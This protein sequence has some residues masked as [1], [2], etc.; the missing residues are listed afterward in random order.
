M[1]ANSFAR[2]GGGGII[3]A[4]LAGAASGSAA[5][6]TASASHGGRM[7]GDCARGDAGASRNEIRQLCLNTV[8]G[9]QTAGG[10]QRSRGG[11][12]FSAAFSPAAFSIRARI[13]SFI[14]AVQ[15]GAIPF[16]RA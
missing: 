4:A 16:E 3:I 8:A 5:V 1:I 7:G 11:Y 12:F 13:I 9:N 14:F 10:R 6:I 15:G 2:Q